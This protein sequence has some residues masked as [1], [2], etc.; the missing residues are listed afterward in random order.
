TVAQTRQNTLVTRKNI[1]LPHSETADEAIII[2]RAEES[3]VETTGIRVGDKRTGQRRC[4]HRCWCR[5][6]LSCNRGLLIGQQIGIE[7][8]RC[9]ST[10]DTRDDALLENVH[11]EDLSKSPTRSQHAACRSLRRRLVKQVAYHSLTEAMRRY[12]PEGCVPISKFSFS[13]QGGRVSTG[14]NCCR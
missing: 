11:Y 1:I 10:D 2:Y 4:R 7:A 14:T 5:R 9:P 3:E 13:S 6:L 8:E 12:E